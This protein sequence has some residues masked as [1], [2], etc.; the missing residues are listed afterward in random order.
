LRSMRIQRAIVGL[1]GPSWS[2]DVT[3]WMG[4]TRRFAYS[5]IKPNITRISHGY[6]RISSGSRTRARVQGPGPRDYHM[7]INHMDYTEYHMDIMLISP[8]ITEYHRISPNITQYHPISPNIT[9][10]LPNITQFHSN[11][12]QYHTK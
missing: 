7:D 12:T 6:N 10:I 4:T 5:R 8:S 2:P 3:S 1:W 9:R 11:I